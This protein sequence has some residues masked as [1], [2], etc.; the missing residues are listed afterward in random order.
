MYLFHEFV[1]VSVSYYH[2]VLITAEYC[3]AIPEQIEAR[4]EYAVIQEFIL[5]E[6]IERTSRDGRSCKD[7]VVVTQ[8][9]QAMQS[10]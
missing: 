2:S 8:P 4:T 5:R 3:I 1:Q 6:D 7:Y 10:F 9:A